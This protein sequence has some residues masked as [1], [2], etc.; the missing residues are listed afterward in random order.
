V[1]VAHGLVLLGVLFHWRQRI[2]AVSG[3]RWGAP[4]L[5]ITHWQRLSKLVETLIGDG[6]A[7][8]TIIVSQG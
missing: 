4:L 3:G 8:F 7:F 1:G 6:S 5:V 2:T